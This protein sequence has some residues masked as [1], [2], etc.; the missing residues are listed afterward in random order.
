MS[1]RRTLVS[2]AVMDLN[3]FNCSKEGL[4][5]PSPNSVS[6]LF[7]YWDPTVNQNGMGS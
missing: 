1:L 4:E 6:K 3:F 7:L 5:S 2:K